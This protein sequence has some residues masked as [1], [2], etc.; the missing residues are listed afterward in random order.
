MQQKNY[1]K[2]GFSLVETIIYISI[3]SVLVTAF[4]SFGN[5]MTVSRLHNQMVLEVN[6]QG[7]K[8]MKTITQTLR[9]ASQ[10]N[11]PTISNTASSL[12]VVTVLP[13]TSPTVFSESGGV[14]YVTEGSG[15]PVPLTN[16]KVVLSNLLFSNFSRPDTANIIKISFTLSSSAPIGG[17]GGSY[18]FTFNGSAD[19]RK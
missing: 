7:A 6:N 8:A 17:P 19:L 14:L 16:N 11:S 1:Y 3:F 9:N 15:S 2:K 10:V 18:S 13:A 5:N 12:S 4:V